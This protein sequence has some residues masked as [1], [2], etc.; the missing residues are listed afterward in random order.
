MS[1]I[2]EL[3]RKVEKKIIYENDVVNFILKIFGTVESIV[4]ALGQALV[5]F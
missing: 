1:I 4:L 5:K 3:L 2:F